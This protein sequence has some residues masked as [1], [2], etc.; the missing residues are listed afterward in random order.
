MTQ[1]IPSLPPGFVVDQEQPQL[2]QGFVLDQP[3]QTGAQILAKETGAGEAFLIGAGSGAAGVL[4]KTKQLFSSP[5]AAFLEQR[6]FEEEQQAIEP[7]REERPISFGAGEIVGET[8][9]LAPIGGVG[10]GVGRTLT[11]KAPQVLQRAATAGAAGAAETAFVG[12][13]IG[14]GAGGAVAAEFGIPLLGKPLAAAYRRVFGKNAD[15]IIKTGGLTQELR[16]KIIREGQDPDELLAKVLDDT[17]EGLN[18]KKEILAQ[19]RGER[20]E[21]FGFD[22][23]EAQRLRDFD[24]QSLKQD[25]LNAEGALGDAARAA[26]QKQQQQIVRGVQERVLDR[27]GA[28]IGGDFA[29]RGEDFSKIELG[30]RIKEA[31]QGLKARDEEAVKL[32]YKAARNADVPNITIKRDGKMGE[33]LV[34]AFLDH[35][36]IFPVD[37]ASRRKGFE[38]LAKFGLIGDVVEKR[39]ADTV[40][41]FNGQKILIRGDVTPLGIKNAE[42]F[43]KRWN[44]INKTDQTGLG[45]V[46]KSETDRVMDKI[47]DAFPD[48]ADQVAGFKAA[49]DAFRNMKNTFEAGDIIQD[50]I[51]LK[52]GKNVDVIPAERF[53]DSAILGSKNR[54]QNIKKLKGAL[55]ANGNAASR[56][57]FSNIKAVTLEEILRRSTKNGQISGAVLNTQLNKMG[58]AALTELYGKKGLIRIKAMA[59]AI[60]DA[61]I[62]LDGTVNYSNTANKFFNFMKRSLSLAQPAI[63]TAGDMVTGAAQSREQRKRLQGGLSILLRKDMNKPASI[64][65]QNVSLEM[66]KYL[67]TLAA[68]GVGQEIATEEQDGVQQ[69]Q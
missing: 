63:G 69:G 44:A 29:V 6:R 55:V 54:V 19:I 5:E 13:D 22:L 26:Q 50:A 58:D 10:A 24:L 45:F 40:I 28:D 59:A 64:R 34:Q 1:Q 17:E 39:G 3:Q 11:R 7:L 47:I 33:G 53:L 9:A 66:A 48:G 14:L 36:E 30:D 49:R 38:A 46:M 12:G 68:A 52:R 60:G 4:S 16:A 18:L 67:N 2:P 15:E 8:G 51:A 65:A 31:I 42:D 62:P 57:A 32:A 43:R 27:F 37:D 25:A 20:A 35:D 61:T 21:M 23:D 41:D 56:Q